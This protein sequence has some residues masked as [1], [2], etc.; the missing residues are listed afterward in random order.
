MTVL[1][2]AFCVLGLDPQLIQPKTQNPK[3]LE[4]Q[5]LAAQG[6]VGEFFP[7]AVL[8]NF[9]SGTY[10][11][12]STPPTAPVGFVQSGVKITKSENDREE[13]GK[14]LESRTHAQAMRPSYGCR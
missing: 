13:L 4:A 12:S 8:K 2:S 6:G 1:L 7:L 11:P 10:I 3:S 9:D 14:C 5:N